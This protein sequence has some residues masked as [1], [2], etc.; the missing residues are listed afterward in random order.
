MFQNKA[1]FIMLPQ[2]FELI[3]ALEPY[4]HKEL[5]PLA[6]GLILDFLLLSTDNR[7]IGPYNV[8]SIKSVSLQGSELQD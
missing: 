3:Y 6:S 7:M 8:F 2:I 4:Y 5:T 1:I